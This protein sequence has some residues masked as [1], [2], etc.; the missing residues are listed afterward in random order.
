[1]VRALS[2]KAPD[3]K[4]EIPPHLGRSS[5]WWVPSGRAG[6]AI[7]L[8]A[9]R[10]RAAI[11]PAFNCWAVM[12]SLERAG[13]APLFVDVS[14]DLNADVEQTMERI[15]TAPDGTVLLLTHQFGVPMRR[16]RDLLIAAQ[17]RGM[18]VIEDGAAAVGARTDAG[19]VGSLGDL[20]VLSF[21]YTKSVFAGDGGLLLASD[22][23]VS[24]AVSASI[25]FRARSA[26]ASV[27]EWLKL[28]AISI[29]THPL[30]Y[31]ST[32]HLTLPPGGTRNERDV[33][34][35]TSLF[36]DLPS[37][38][39]RQ[40]AGLTWQRLTATLA[41]RRRIS[42]AYL[43]GLSELPLTL[44]PAVAA[45]EAA[46]IRFPLLVP[47]RDQFIDRCTRA[48]LDLGRSFPY[49]CSDTGFRHAEAV[50]ATI[51]NL[52]LSGRLEPRIPEIIDIV[53]RAAR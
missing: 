22:R 38:W 23:A 24:D 35:H 50:A 6:L 18:P 33:P 9:L 7:G 1:M 10:A 29:L 37:R 44:V 17:G 34:A 49:T 48:G 8:A 40:L 45:D 13:T 41:A 14:E 32:L 12:H 52:P 51:V 46:P 4:T 28:F 11:V 39:M 47:R 21:Q 2:A 3:L 53:R 20:S 15:R 26:R 30:A 27:R 42:R 31:G 5:A 19:P 25:V 43:D 16:T 36:R